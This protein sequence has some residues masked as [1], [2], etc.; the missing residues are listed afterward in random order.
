MK[1][2][3]LKLD[4]EQSKAVEFIESIYSYERLVFT[5]EDVSKRKRIKNAI[6]GLNRCNAKRANNE[7]CTRKQKEGHMFCGTHVK[8][9]PHGVISVDDNTEKQII[10]GEVFAVDINGIVFY[11]DKHNNVYKTEDILNNK[12]NPE[13]IT[14][15]SRLEND[16]L[17]VPSSLHSHP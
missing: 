5:K 9:T 15:Y 7:Q 16:E 14:K 6:P 11:V 12:Q 17:Y 2:M 13:I 1:E 8:G 3:V 4:L 10:K